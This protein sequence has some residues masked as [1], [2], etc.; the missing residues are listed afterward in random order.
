MEEEEVLVLVLSKIEMIE[1]FYYLDLTVVVSMDDD[2]VS[3]LSLKPVLGLVFAEQIQ[4][5]FDSFFSEV[6]KRLEKKWKNASGKGDVALI[7]T[8]ADV[9]AL[10]R[11]DRVFVLIST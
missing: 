6:S 11:P 2:V 1:L 5:D 9:L 4:F 8:R 7:L 3:M 10:F